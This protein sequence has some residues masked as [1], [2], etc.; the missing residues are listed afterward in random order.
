MSSVVVVVA[1]LV[2]LAIAITFATAAVV[3]LRPGDRA[4]RAAENELARQGGTADL[5]VRHHVRFAET[6][7]ESVLPFAIAVA[8]AS[9]AVLNVEGG[10]SAGLQPGSSTP[11]SCS[12]VGS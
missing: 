10:T 3:A 12:R 4:Q 6:P 11:Y 7:T 1:A 8:L 9:L 2:Q 5:L